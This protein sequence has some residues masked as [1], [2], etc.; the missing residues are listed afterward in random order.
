MRLCWGKVQKFIEFIFLLQVDMMR[1]AY[2]TRFL[3][4]YISAGYYR[5]CVEFYRNAP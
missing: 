5:M 4:R 1:R 2:S 3:F